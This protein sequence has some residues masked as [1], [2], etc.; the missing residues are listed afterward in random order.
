MRG[1]ARAEFTLRATPRV[2][3]SLARAR[4]GARARLRARVSLLRRM[5]LSAA[6]F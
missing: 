4:I 1:D 6:R 2:H 5:A 3:I